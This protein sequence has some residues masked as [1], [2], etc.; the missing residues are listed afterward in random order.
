MSLGNFA[1]AEDSGALHRQVGEILGHVRA[2][3]EQVRDLRV[4]SLRREERLSEDIN[5][6]RNEAIQ[7]RQVMVGRIEALVEN[8]RDLSSK[9]KD[10]VDDIGRVNKRVEK[11]ETPVQQMDEF[12]KRIIRW[13]LIVASVIGVVWSMISGTISTGVQHFVGKLFGL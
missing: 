4:D 3:T 5:V 6:V 2:L 9:T 12:R 8:V 1:V 7:Q 13:G 11:L 10:V